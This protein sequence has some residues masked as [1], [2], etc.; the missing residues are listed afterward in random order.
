MA[1]YPYVPSTGTSFSYTTTPYDPGS[2]TS[3]AFTPTIFAP[4][5]ESRYYEGLVVV[6]E[7]ASISVMSGAGTVT[8]PNTQTHYLVTAEITVEAGAGQRN[9]L[10]VWLVPAEIT[11]EAGEISLTEGNRTFPYVD[12]PGHRVGYDTGYLDAV[13]KVSGGV[14]ETLLTSEMRALN[15]EDFAA[16]LALSSG[17]SVFLKFPNDE[18]V[19]SGYF[20]RWLGTGTISEIAWSDDS[21]DG[22][23]GA[24]TASVD[25]PVNAGPLVS[26]YRDAV[27]SIS[28]FPSVGV[29]CLRFT[30]TG[31]VALA[32]LHL[33][34]TDVP[35]WPTA[36]GGLVLVD[37]LTTDLLD[38]DELNFDPI[39]LPSSDTV[40]CRLRNVTTG[41]IL[42]D[43]EVTVD[44]LTAGTPDCDTQVY[45]SVDNRHFSS[46][47][48]FD[49][50]GPGN[51]SKTLF[52]RRV[53]PSS[54]DE[55]RPWAYR[56]RTSC[57]EMSDTTFYGYFG[58]RSGTPQPH[59]WGTSPMQIV[60]GDLTSVIGLGMGP[61]AS[62]YS[63]A[64]YGR[65]GMY[66][67][68]EF[69]L[70]DW[71]HVEASANAYTSDRE[72]DLDTGTIDP[73]HTEIRT[74]LEEE[75]Y[76]PTFSVF[77]VLEV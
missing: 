53:N 62:T 59:V 29:R 43:I 75:Y 1:T 72:I 5:A 65:T 37:P 18:T 14:P 36:L 52:V 77:L 23:D 8:V 47:V 33:Y 71:T 61:E 58:V 2:A 16:A 22:T 56:I 42:S 54:Y 38:K 69:Y 48:S 26:S 73:E 31:S 27:N 25:T 19:I 67:A 66:D 9:Y 49:A 12:P 60:N 6:L 35:T 15:S 57:T 44:A 64:V 34:V 17:D 30:T 13:N 40:A 28:D 46:T 76:G 51:T 50:M 68:S 41:T 39:F 7:T 4:G 10:K 70:Y 74:I 24:W 63:A 55:S 45:L 20:L 11:V 21:T 3:Y 32:A